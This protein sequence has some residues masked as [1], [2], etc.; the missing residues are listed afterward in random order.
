M[1]DQQV[2][3]ICISIA[4][5]LAVPFGMLIYSNSPILEAK[6]TLRA[7]TGETKATLRGEMQS[8]RAGMDLWFER[9][10][11]KIDHLAE[12]VATLKELLTTH[13]REHH[14]MK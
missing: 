3:S 13:L 10:E 1:T 11:N 14:G 2:L 12:E 7:E 6:E 4:I 9:L 5:S 8:L